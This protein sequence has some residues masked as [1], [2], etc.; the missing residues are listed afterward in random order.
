MK[1][2]GEFINIFHMA[3]VAPLLFWIG[4]TRGNVP[5]FVWMLLMV[6]AVV[7][8]AYHGYRLY[9]RYQEKQKE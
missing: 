3:V 5:Q 4:Y 2:Q 9:Q 7:V 1:L 6:L 8:V